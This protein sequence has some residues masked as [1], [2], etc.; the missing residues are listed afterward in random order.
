[1]MLLHVINQEIYYQNAIEKG[2]TIA[3]LSNFLYSNVNFCSNLFV[4]WTINN[5]FIYKS[6]FFLIKSWYQMMKL[7]I[8]YP[9][10]FGLY[11]KAKYRAEVGL[12]IWSEWNIMNASYSKLTTHK[13][14]AYIER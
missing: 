12:E 6:I 10:F 11:T 3:F 7:I 8:K 13:E 14:N 1:M 2:F 9:L 4:F 5:L